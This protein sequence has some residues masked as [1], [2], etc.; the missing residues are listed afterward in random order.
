MKR[1]RWFNECCLET[2]KRMENGSVQLVFT[3]PPYSI[4]KQ[5]EKGVTLK[6]NLSLNE[7]VIKECVRVLHP[8][9]S[10]CWQVGTNVIRGKRSER[11]PLDIVFYEMFKKHGLQLRNRIVW[12][13][14]DS[15]NNTYSFT[16]V[17]EVILWFTK[18]D[19]YYFDLDSVRVPQSWPNKKSYK[20]HNYG[21]LTCNPLGKNPGDVWEMSRVK[22]GHSE[23]I[24]N[25]HPCQ[26]PEELVGR[27]IKSMTKEG[28]IVLDPFGGVGTTVVT[29]LKTKRFGV[30]S[31][32]NRDYYLLG[33]ARIKKA[34]FQVV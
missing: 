14:R 11:L 31:E 24:P 32:I 12:I 13:A 19:N 26:F 2:L 23:K 34:L 17:Y 1:Y 18:T 9:G 30:S 8:N 20:K 28:D 5:Y 6:E 22:H 15:I 3:S 7:K 27:A 10:I 33:V 4:G 16:G 25:G 21:K 29:A